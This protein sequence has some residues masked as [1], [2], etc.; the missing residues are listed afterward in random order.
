LE[1]KDFEKAVGA[2][3]ISAKQV[4]HRRA[5][6]DSA[7][8]R[9]ERRLGGYQGEGAKT[10]IRQKHLPN[11]PHVSFPIRSHTNRQARRKARSKAAAE[12]GS[13]QI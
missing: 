8:A 2:P 11:S 7:D 3:A 13:L 10:V 5:P 4:Y 6:L 12:N 1:E 9:I